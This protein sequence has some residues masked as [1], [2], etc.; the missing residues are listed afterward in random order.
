MSRTVALGRVLQRGGAT[1]S[2]KAEEHDENGAPAVRGKGWD[3]SVRQ[4][5]EG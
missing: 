3:A 5:H 2:M 1:Y 4:G